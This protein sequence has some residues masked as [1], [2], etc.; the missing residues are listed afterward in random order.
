[1]KPATLV[2]AVIFLILGG[3]LALYVEAQH[4]TH[5]LP[6]GHVNRQVPGDPPVMVGDGSLHAHS[7]NHW[8]TDGADGDT[9]IV[10]NTGTLQTSCDFSPTVGTTTNPA[11]AF[12]WTDDEN[13]YDVSPKDSTWSIVITNRNGSTVTISLKGTDLQFITDNGSSFTSSANGGEDYD[14]RQTPSSPVASIVVTG[15][16]DNTGWAKA[17]KFHPHYSLGFCYK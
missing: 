8:R 13:I 9:K 2:T 10:P 16:N 1:M 4:W 5:F 6:V 3:A 12:L 11:S 14:R 15:A 7:R 17:S